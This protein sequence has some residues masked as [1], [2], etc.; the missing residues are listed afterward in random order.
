MAPFI[1][2]SEKACSEEEYSSVENRATHDAAPI[3][4]KRFSLL[5][6]GPSSLFRFKFGLKTTVIL[7]PIKDG[8]GRAIG[9]ELSAKA[10]TS[11][12]S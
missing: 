6:A 3:L 2:I 10:A 1:A 7:L 11:G 4:G 5:S 8:Y 12:L 9:T